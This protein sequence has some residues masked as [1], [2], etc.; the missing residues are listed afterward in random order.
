MD[1]RQYS[2]AC[3]RNRGPILEVLREEVRS[4][5]RVLEVASGTGMHAVWF[6]RA[7]PVALWQPTDPVQESLVSIDAWRA[8]DGD[9]RLLPPLQ[10]DVHSAEWPAGEWDVVYVANMIHIAPASATSA[11]LHGA[12]RALSAG[13]RLIVYGP[14]GEG[15]WMAQGNIAFHQDL[16]RRNPE[17][18]VRELEWVQEQAA[19]AG[20]ALIRAVAMPANNLTLVFERAAD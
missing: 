10:L 7:L 3:E 9:E 14:F 18:G 6:S 4:G 16:Q 12:S 1:E 20:L 5:A 17:W 19:E 8:S 2:A 13:G 15:G 11:L